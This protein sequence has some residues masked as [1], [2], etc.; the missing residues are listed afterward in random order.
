LFACWERCGAKAGKEQSWH[1]IARP[2]VHGHDLNCMTIVKGPGNHRY[3]SGADEKVARVFEAPGAFLDSL[4]VFT[5]N[6]NADGFKRED[7][8][9]VGA[10]MS[11]LGLSQRP[12]YSQGKAIV[13]ICFNEQL[14]YGDEGIVRACQIGQVFG[15]SEP[16]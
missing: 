15:S 16:A 14:L 4:A 7:V 5:G 8:Q 13:C 3:V 9:I 6:S 12:I 2:Q 10:N 1:E 11:A